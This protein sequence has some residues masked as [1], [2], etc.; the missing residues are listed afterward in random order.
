M[1]RLAGRGGARV[2]GYPRIT[3]VIGVKAARHIALSLRRPM[4]LPGVEYVGSIVSI[5]LTTGGWRS[6]S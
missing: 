1:N 4:A 3:Y 5:P 2:V 6:A